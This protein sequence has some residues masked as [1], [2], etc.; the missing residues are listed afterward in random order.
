MHPY[1]SI[2][3]HILGT[4]VLSYASNLLEWMSSQLVKEWEEAS[5]VNNNSSNKN[6]FP[7]DPSK[8]DLLLDPSE[9]VQLS[10]PKIVLCSGIDLKNGDMSSEALQYLCQDEKTTIVLTEKTHFGLDNTINSQLYN[11]WYNLT[12][13]K[14]GGTVEDGVAV[15]LEKVVS[16]ENWNRE[17]P[18]IG[19]EL[20]DFQEKI[21]LQ[22]KQKLLA[23]VRDRKNQNLLNADTINGDDSSS[24]EEDDVVSS[25]DEAAALKYTEAPANADASTHNKR[26]R[27]C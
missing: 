25:D 27:C 8:V 7:F 26:A 12:K 15:P 3:Y 21:N 6:N 14:Q 10:G 5:S 17:E 4:K 11:D 9:L 18:L 24:D 2:S 23:K 1:L 22:R 16:L 20:T 13:Q 19:A